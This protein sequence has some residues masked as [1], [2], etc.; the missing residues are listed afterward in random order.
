M[1][2]TSSSEN[3]STGIVQEILDH[4]ETV[5]REHVLW[6]FNTIV[7]GHASLAVASVHDDLIG[8]EPDGLDSRIREND[9]P[10]RAAIFEVVVETAFE[11]FNL[12]VDRSCRVDQLTA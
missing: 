9:V 10:K 2:D 1:F 4:S 8:E 7:V 11:L 12:V 3:I 5:K 6:M